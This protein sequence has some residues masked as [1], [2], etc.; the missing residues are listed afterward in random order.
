D[1]GTGGTDGGPPGSVSFAPAN[2][3]KLEVDGPSVQ[4]PPGAVTVATAVSG[5][6]S[7]TTT[8]LPRAADLRGKIYDFKPDG[9]TFAKAVLITLPVTG[10]PPTG[11]QWVVA[12]HDTA[13][14][15]WVPLPTILKATRAISAT[16]HFTQ[17]ALLETNKVDTSGG[18]NVPAPCGGALGSHYDLGGACYT[19]TPPT[20]GALPFCPTT[21]VS[22][23]G[24]Y[25][26][27][28]FDFVSA[29]STYF[30]GIT[31][32]TFGTLT[33]QKACVDTLQ[34]SF[35][36][37]TTC[38]DLEAPLLGAFKQAIV[39]EG[40]RNVECTCNNLGGVGQSVETGTYSTSGNDLTLTS[41]KGTGNVSYCSQNNNLYFADGTNKFDYIFVP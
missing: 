12:W 6:S 30:Y 23:S 38:E 28:L 13:N 4:P 24:A 19:G 31:V 9:T 5:T 26:A 21:S 36:T 33:L 32:A 1:S 27:G 7:T 14:A 22:Q 34:G 29:G 17:F 20:A 35:G 15:K 11:K 16:T 8:G 25:A 10:T 37:I 41:S 39:C 40:N 18:C 2:G 3:G